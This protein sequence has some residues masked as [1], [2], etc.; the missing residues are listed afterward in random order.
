LYTYSDYAA[1][2]EMP[3]GFEEDIAEHK[4]QYS[5]TPLHIRYYVSDYIS[6]TPYTSYLKDVQG[7]ITKNT[8]ILTAEAAAWKDPSLQS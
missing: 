8:A 6:D 1:P 2:S 5:G 7:P 4:N 3:Q